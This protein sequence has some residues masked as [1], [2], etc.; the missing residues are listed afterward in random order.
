MI[1]LTEKI[2]YGFGDMASSMFWKLFGAY[3][4]IFY[5]DVFGLPAAMVGTMFLITRIWDSFFDP[6]VGVVADRT[7]SRWGKFRP[8][9]LY[10]AIP[11][12]LIGVLTFY[13]SP[14]GNIGKLIYAYFTYSLMMMVYSGI[15]VPYAS[16]LGVM[17]PDSSERN[18]LSTYRMMFAYLGSF[19]ALLLFMPMVN[20]FNGHSQLLA[21]QQKGW[22]MAV[23]VI[24]AMCA[25]LFL[26]CF[27]WTRERVKP[28]KDKKTSLKEDVRDL[29]HN[30]PWWILFG[31]GVATLV[32]NSIR[33]GAAVYYFKYFVVEEEYPTISLMGVSFVLSGLYLSVGQIANIIGVVFAAPMSNKIGKK[34]TFAYSML[35]ASV[36]SIIFFWLDKDDMVLIFIFQCLI[37]ICAGCIF[38]LLWSMYA[39]C[40]D[41]SELKTGNRATGLI[42]SA[43]SM[44]QK[45]GWAIGT[46]V[47]GWLLS[48]FGFQANAIQSLETIN[49]IKMFLSLLPAVAAF[50]SVIFI[51]FYP[52]GESKMKDIMEQLNLKR[53]IKN[54]A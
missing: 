50:I 4:M 15:N 43:S 42:F 28:I 47:T 30:K 53:T 54:E 40:A 9:L 33:D 37:S 39:D 18:T 51:V 13:T 14:F 52:L 49:G 32:F 36:L 44:S 1:K 34:R 5:T 11:F 45:F 21:D 27:A 6:I 20:A 7:S 29:F 25:L 2:G 23:I 24:A 16:L 8:Y 3:L 22:F 35:L 38:P 41:Y 26:G 46:A 48:F 12:A 10:L 19:I 31:A 17:S